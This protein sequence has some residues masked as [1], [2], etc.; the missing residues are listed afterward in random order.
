M[1]LN[2][3]NHHLT[4]VLT[5]EALINEMVFE[6]YD[7]SENDKA[8]VMTK[9]GENIGGLPVLAEAR[10]SYLAENDTTD[11][12]P[13]EEIHRYIEDLSVHEYT[14]EEREPIESGFPSLYQNNNNLEEF[15]IRYQVNPINVWY[16][17]K[18]NNVIPEQRMH[19]LAM[20]FLTDM[21]REIL[22]EDEDGIIPLV[23]NA[24]EKVLLD[25]I[26]EKFMEKISC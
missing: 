14:A 10:D 16:W 12:F 19:T 5:N 11:E 6:V 15:C 8:M 21:V 9:E 26:E 13:L 3:E 7:F 24:G 20:E 2:L 18:Q 1:F 23:P 4:Q 22:M 25:R 17:F